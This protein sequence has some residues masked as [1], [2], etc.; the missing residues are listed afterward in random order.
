[1]HTYDSASFDY[2]ISG[3]RKYAIES[4]LK[5]LTQKIKDNSS[6]VIV[7]HRF[8]WRA[9]DDSGFTIAIKDNGMGFAIPVLAHKWNKSRNS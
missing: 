1:M 7:G 3:T 9:A 4:A 8:T 5:F 2:P 6:L